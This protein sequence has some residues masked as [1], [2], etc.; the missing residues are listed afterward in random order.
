MIWVAYSIAWVTCACVSI[1]GM[2]YFNDYRFVAIMCIP[3]FI[4]ARSN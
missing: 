4:K 2:R 1:F 3:L